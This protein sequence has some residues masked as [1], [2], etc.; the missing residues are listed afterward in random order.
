MTSIYRSL[1]LILLG[2]PGSGKGT[3]ARVLAER[4]DV[5]HVSTGDMLRDEVRRGTALGRQA[6][7]MMDRGELVP[8]HV[9]AGIVLRRLDQEDATRGVILDGYPRNVEQ[10]GVLDGILAE[11]GRT[12]E[13]V[14]LISV[15]DGEIVRRLGAR[16]SCTAC[17]R[18]YNLELSPPS[19]PGACDG[20]G[21]P[22]EL[23]DDDR[24]PVVRERLRQYRE[25]TTPLVEFY[26]ARGLLVEVDGAQKM[27]AVAEAIVE[28]IGAPVAG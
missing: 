14:A 7:E 23:R 21:G 19:K 2:P 13:R 20:C 1:N 17:G 27:E 24:E 16:R 9:V 18:V 3:Q 6:K 4:Y 28:A 15:P 22:L 26:R 12:L 10:A 25:K 8:D 5:P 11:L